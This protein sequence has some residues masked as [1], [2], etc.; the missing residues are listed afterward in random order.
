MKSYNTN[1]YMLADNAP[2]YP[3]VSDIKSNDIRITIF[4][5]LNVTFVVQQTDSGILEN[6]KKK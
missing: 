3:S 5:P 6:L 1:M 2:F 4:L